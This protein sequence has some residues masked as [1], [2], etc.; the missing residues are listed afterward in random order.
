MERK[1]MG[2]I[3]GTAWSRKC[4]NFNLPLLGSL[5]NSLSS[6]SFFLCFTFDHI[7]LL[8]LQRWL[9]LIQTRNWPSGLIDLRCE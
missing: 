7:D 9:G 2:L 6:A 8:F 1:T 5:M 4:F 3:V